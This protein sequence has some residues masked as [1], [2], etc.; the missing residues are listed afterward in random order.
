MADWVYSRVALGTLTCLGVHS[1]IRKWAVVLGMI[2]RITRER[3]QLLLAGREQ[4]ALH[5]GPWEVRHKEQRQ[6]AA[7]TC[8]VCSWARDSVRELAWPASCCTSRGRHVR[9]VCLR[10]RYV[11]ALGLR[12]DRARRVSLMLL[13]LIAS[14]PCALRQPS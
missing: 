4:V 10:D 12:T 7:S 8:D 6:T 9:N 3:E 14:T 13:G 5:K 2:M 1:N 11:S